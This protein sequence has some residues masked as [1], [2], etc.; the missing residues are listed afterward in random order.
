MEH[1]Q[2]ALRATQSAAPHPAEQI[3]TI[4][5]QLGYF[6]YLTYDALVW[7][8]SVKFF[9]VKPS[10]ASTIGKRANQFWLTGILCSIAFGLLKVSPLS[11]LVRTNADCTLRA[12]V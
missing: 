6:G 9:N 12:R 2:A 5:R 10:T 8:N 11:D 4:G 7:A 1:L 3:T